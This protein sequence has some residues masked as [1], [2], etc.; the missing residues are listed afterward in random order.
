MK[1]T[2]LDSKIAA[3]LIA[4]GD[5]AQRISL[6]DDESFLEPLD[7]QCAIDAWLMH[8]GPLNQATL[9]CQLARITIPPGWRNIVLFDA[10]DR[11][12]QTVSV[13][14]RLAGGQEFSLNTASVVG[15]S[16]LAKSTDD[17]ANPLAARGSTTTF[18][19]DLVV[20]PAGDAL[21]HL[22]V[23]VRN[24]TPLLSKTYPWL[25]WW[26]VDNRAAYSGSLSLKK[27]H[28]FPGA[29]EAIIPG[30]AHARVVVILRDD[31]SSDAIT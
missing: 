20:R 10:L 26:A 30:V 3:E 9:D 11:T 25:D 6:E 12:E 23:F 1:R 5:I 2:D 13:A 24:P 19:N 29:F 27:G 7:A 8:H 17:I 28:T 15:C 14:V 31:T 18:L 22:G 4:Q 16:L 21:R